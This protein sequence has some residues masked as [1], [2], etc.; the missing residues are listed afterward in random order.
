MQTKG[1]EKLRLLE[2]SWVALVSKNYEI[3][4]ACSEIEKEIDRFKNSN[5]PSS[6]ST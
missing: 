2:S 1:G 3:E 5:N 4:E 6:S